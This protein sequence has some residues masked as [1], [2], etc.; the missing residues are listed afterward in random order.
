M[1]FCLPISELLFTLF[2]PLITEHSIQYANGL[3]WEERRK[4]MYPTLRDK[5]LEDYIPCFINVS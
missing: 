1:L 2:E 3:D 4:A 5:C